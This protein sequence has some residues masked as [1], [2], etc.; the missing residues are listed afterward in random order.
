MEFKG[1]EKL[2]SACMGHTLKFKMENKVEKH[3]LLLR[4]PNKTLGDRGKWDW[5]WR[6]KKVFYV[7]HATVNDLREFAR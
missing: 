6:E 3:S 1:K 5:S 4:G 2:E 7:W